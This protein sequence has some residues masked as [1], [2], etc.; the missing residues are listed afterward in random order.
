MENFVWENEEGFW[1]IDIVKREGNRINNN[2]QWY[3]WIKIKD[4]I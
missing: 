1:W 4:P 2:G 3:C